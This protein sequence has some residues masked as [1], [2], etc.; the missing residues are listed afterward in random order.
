[1]TWRLT[2]CRGIPREFP[3]FKPFGIYFKYPIHLVDESGFLTLAAEEGSLEGNQVKGRITQTTRKSD[4]REQIIRYIE[5]KLGA[6]ETVTQKGISEEFE[7][8]ILTVRRDLKAINNSAVEPVYLVD[9]LGRI[10]NP[11][12][13]IKRAIIRIYIEMIGLNR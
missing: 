4:R 11:G 3:T 12:R 9:E 7:V 13:A 2:R 8:S 10:S 6:G 1:M 5:E